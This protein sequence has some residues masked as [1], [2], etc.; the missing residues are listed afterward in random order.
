MVE[1]ILFGSLFVSFQGI[2][3]NK[4]KIGRRGSRGGGVRVRHKGESKEFV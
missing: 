3:D 2:V 4:L 1:K